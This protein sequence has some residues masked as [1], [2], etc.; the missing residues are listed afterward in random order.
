MIEIVPL[1]LF[2]LAIPDDGPGEIE[3]TRYPALFETEEECRDFG[4]R[5]VRAR[6]TIE[7]ENATLF[8][9]FCEPVPDR[10]EFAKLFDTLSEKRQRSSEAR[11]Q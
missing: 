8:Q 1:M 6:V 9:I 7:H 5:V 11:D 10:E 2:L 3:L 4:E